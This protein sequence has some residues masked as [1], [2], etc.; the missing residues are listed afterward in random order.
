MGK[1]L[2]LLMLTA[3]LAVFGC[4]HSKEGQN[5]THV[6]G[7]FTIRYFL[8]KMKPAEREAFLKEAGFEL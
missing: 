7:G 8:E 2:S 5:Y 1:F 4:S 3:L 6:I